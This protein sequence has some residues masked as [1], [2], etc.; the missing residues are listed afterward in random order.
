MCSSPVIPQIL[1]YT[2]PSVSQPCTVL[3]ASADALPALKELVSRGEEIFE[4]A[5]ADTL[6]ALETITSRKPVLVALSRLFAATPRGAALIN[7]INADP[8]LKHTE[9]R[10]VSLNAD[11]RR[12]R[13]RPQGGTP[14]GRPPAAA[15]PDAA[16]PASIPVQPLDERGTRRAPRTRVAGHVDV[17]VNGH[18]ATLIDISPLG[19]Q[20]VSTAALKPR[21]KVR[22]GL[23]DEQGDIRLKASIAWASF[24]VSP[25]GPRYRAGIEFIEPSTSAVEA[26]IGRHKDQ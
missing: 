24:E 16:A 13:R 8:G 19:M 12:G 20:V 17:L 14:A 5:D 7:R 10:V 11:S 3:V 15:A 23:V 21:R 22:V 9:V 4:F 18:E 6:Q 2:V 26:Y 25:N 1:P